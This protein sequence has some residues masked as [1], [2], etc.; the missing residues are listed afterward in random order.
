MSNDLVA[1]LA[2]SAMG[3]EAPAEAAA[4]PAAAAA[5]AAQ[6][7]PK[8]PQ[9]GDTTAK[10]ASEAA[11]A[12]GSPKDEADAMKAEAI[13]YEIDGRK[14]TP[15]QIKGTFDRYRDLNFKHQEMGDLHRVAEIAQQLGLGQ[16]PRDVARVFAE[17]LREKA[18][19]PVQQG[20]QT[21]EG[22]LPEDDELAKWEEENAAKLPPGYRELQSNLRNFGQGQQQLMEMVR[23]ALAQSG[24]QSG[25]AADTALQAR[26]QR[27]S[28]MRERIKHNLESMA[29]RVG[30]SPDQ[31]QDF[32]LFAGERGY[33]LE[34]FIDGNLTGTVMQ[35]F[36]ANMATPE[37]ERLREIAQRRQAFTGSIAAS[38]S[39]GDAAPPPGGE[40]RL[41]GLVEAALTAKGR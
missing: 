21:Q 25:Q 22:R 27:S 37:M 7:A 30:V 14:L 28:L 40:G 39:G 2:A 5:A 29:Q 19:A 13:L 16:N 12:A 32:M 4:D 35:D 36:K 24:A 10:T 31:A 8:G 20:G 3:L 11:V 26:E 33:T 17:M 34:D 18:N 15:S 9:G 38:P 1:Q 6:A 41:A 23:A